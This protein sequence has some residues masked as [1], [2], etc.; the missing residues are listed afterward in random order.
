M[1]I[2]GYHRTDNEIGKSNNAKEIFYGCRADYSLNELFSVGILF[3]HSEFNS[4]L[5]PSSVYD[6]KGNKFNC[7][8]LAYSFELGNI[9]LFGETARN[10][11]L[12]TI[13][14]MALKISKYI[15]TII[16]VRYYPA[17]YYPLHS[18]GVSESSTKNETGIYTGINV[19]TGIGT[20]N[21]FIDQYKFPGSTYYNP[22]PSSGREFYL[23][24]EVRPLRNTHLNFRY[25]NERKEV[26]GS[27]SEQK[28]LYDQLTQSTK[29]ELEYNI[30]KRI[31]LK[32]RFDYVNFLISGTGIN[33]NG[34]MIYQDIKLNL[35]RNFSAY[36]RA[37]FFQTDSYNSRVYQYR[38]A[39]G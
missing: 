1:V 29:S 17:D 31:R 16:S 23:N 28:K 9:Y 38:R 13:N 22:L 3:Y 24:Y 27:Y 35:H 18:S 25:R 39:N 26:T 8:S 4:P 7:Y 32:S 12:S 30:S 36:I 15:S 33:E 34:F 20:F 5:Q 19:K 2:D 11:S 21:F 37:T 10:N 14:S 6:I